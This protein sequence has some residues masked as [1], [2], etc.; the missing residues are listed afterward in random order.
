MKREIIWRELKF[1]GTILL[2]CT[3][4]SLGFDLFLDPNNINVGGITGIAMILRELL[5][6]GSI[7]AYFAA[8]NIPLFLLGYKE[9]GRRFFIGSMLGMLFSTVLL[10]LLTII[11]VPK[12]DLMLAALYGGGL[13]GLGLGL[14]FMAGA[15]TGGSDIM[16]K[17]LRK[18]FR[19]LNL[20]RLMLI[21]D[22]ITVTLTGVVFHDITRTLYSALPLYVSALVMDSVIY[23]LDYSSMALIISD[24][25]SEI[26]AEIARKLERGTT[27]LDAHGGYHGDSRQVVMCAIRRRQITELKDLVSRIDPNAFMILQDAHQVLGEG[28]MRYSDTI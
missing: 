22:I 16:A 27:L 15:S 8:I 25:Y 18:R 6:F 3:V 1:V 26:V 24:K 12:I 10:D 17:L 9:L 11:P 23:G 13:T 5:G 4:F 21:L 20:S 28:F 7:G 19:R 14:V 2:G